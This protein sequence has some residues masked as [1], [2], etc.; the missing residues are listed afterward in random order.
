M[1]PLENASRKLKS[2]KYRTG[3]S[4]DLYSRKLSWNE[5]E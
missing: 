3:F 5:I 2:R 4:D 1:I